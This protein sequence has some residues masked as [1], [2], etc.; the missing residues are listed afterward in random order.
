VPFSGSG[1]INSRWG[2]LEEFSELGHQPLSFRLRYAASRVA[3]QLKA[4]ED[5]IGCTRDDILTELYG[6][7]SR[8]MEDTPAL[9]YQ[10]LNKGWLVPALGLA[11]QPRFDQPLD[12]GNHLAFFAISF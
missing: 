9:R 11:I 3:F 2:K 8:I 12:D 6:R 10:E 5:T 1:T 7:M 4:I